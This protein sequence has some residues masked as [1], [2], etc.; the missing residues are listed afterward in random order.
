MLR[1]S[2]VAEGAD[3]GNRAAV[4]AG[5]RALWPISLVSTVRG[6]IQGLV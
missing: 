5:G 4:A 3:R 1:C 6:P 2:M